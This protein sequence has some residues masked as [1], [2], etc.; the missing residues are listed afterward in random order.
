VNGTMNLQKL[1]DVFYV[2][3]P[4]FGQENS[5]PVSIRSRLAPRLAFLA[6]GLGRAF[7]GV[8]L[9]SGLH[10]LKQLEDKAIDLVPRDNR[11]VISTLYYYSYWINFNNCNSQQGMR[12]GAKSEA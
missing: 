2:G 10:N 9:G 1:D 7:N 4:A 8:L 12:A 5:T 11:A 3:R 6:A